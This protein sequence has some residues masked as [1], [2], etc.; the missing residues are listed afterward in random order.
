MIRRWWNA[1]WYG[2]PRKELEPTSLF[3]T[4]LLAVAA[5]LMASGFGLASALV[6]LDW[7]GADLPLLSDVV[8]VASWLVIGGLLVRLTAALMRPEPVYLS[9]VDPQ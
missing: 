3:R 4:L 9:R 1:F 5:F 2:F 6:V 8:V 7:A